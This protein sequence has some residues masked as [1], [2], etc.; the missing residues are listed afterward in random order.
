MI[1]TIHSRQRSFYESS[2]MIISI[3]YIRD[4]F[5]QLKGRYK[6]FHNNLPYFINVIRLISTTRRNEIL[7]TKG[8]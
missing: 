6:C 1:T 3:H 8:T 4:K 5:F 2:G 7:T